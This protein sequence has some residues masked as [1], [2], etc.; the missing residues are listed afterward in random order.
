[1]TGRRSHGERDEDLGGTGED[2]CEKG[3]VEEG[4]V[5]GRMYG[6]ERGVVHRGGIQSPGGVD[7]GCA[8]AEGGRAWDCD[9]CGLQIDARRSE[10]LTEKVSFL[11]SLGETDGKC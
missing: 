4:L 9:A 6:A 7:G 3:G 11:A 5:V 10:D 2:M 1:M 8:A